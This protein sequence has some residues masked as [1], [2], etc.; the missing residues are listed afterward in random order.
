MRGCLLSS[1]CFVRTIGCV[2]VCVCVYDD[3]IFFDCPKFTEIV[4]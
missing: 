1:S 4:V 2:C 3:D